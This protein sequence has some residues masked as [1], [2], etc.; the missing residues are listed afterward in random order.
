MHLVPF[1]QCHKRMQFL[2]VGKNDKPAGL[3]LYAMTR[4]VES[5]GFI[6]VFSFNFFFLCK[7][8]L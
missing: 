7:F 8:A 5:E 2:P 1:N 3:L 4:D 6:K